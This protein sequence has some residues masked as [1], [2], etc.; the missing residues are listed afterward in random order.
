MYD[1][2]K[3]LDSKGIILACVG[4]IAVCIAINIA[5]AVFPPWEGRM[6]PRARNPQLEPTARPKSQVTS[7][8]MGRKQTL[9]M[10]RARRPRLT[11]RSCPCPTTCRRKRPRQVSRTLS[12]HTVT[13]LTSEYG[14]PEK[15]AYRVERRECGNGPRWLRYPLLGHPRLLPKRDGDSRDRRFHQG[16]GLQRRDVL[17]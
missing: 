5:F 9:R 3:K 14:V 15:T 7:Q 16:R 17:I 4:I 10:D 13:S 1:K 6:V 11:P 2:G 12:P 8:M